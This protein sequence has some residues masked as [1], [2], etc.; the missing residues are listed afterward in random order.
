MATDHYEVLGVRPMASLAEIELALKGRRSQYHPD[1]YASMDEGTIAWA[2]AQTQ[3]VNEAF[4]VLSD[5][6]LRKAFDAQRSQAKGRAQEGPRGADRPEPQRKA[7][8][9]EPKA[10]QDRSGDVNDGPRLQDHLSRIELQGEDAERFHLAPR[11]P[12]KKLAA[13]LANRRFAQSAPPAAV[14]LLVDDTMFRGGADGLLITDEYISFK[15][16]FLDSVDYRYD[17]GMGWRGGFRA[18]KRTIHRFERECISFTLVSASGAQQ[19]TWALNSYFEERLQWYLA[20][21][22]LGDADAQFFVSGSVDDEEEQLDWLTRA[23]RNGHVVAQHNLGMTLM[24]RDLDAA[25]Q[26][27]VLAA[28]QGSKAARDRLQSS[29]FDRFRSR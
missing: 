26:W 4:R 16:I 29:R 27:F 10:A 24:S 1:R 8:Q 5:P 25:F 7:K 14:L 3:A 6:A 20:R 18:N 23:A 12:P 17:W 2:T 19:L 11:I 21:A 22:E 28:A 13:A 9:A 15:S